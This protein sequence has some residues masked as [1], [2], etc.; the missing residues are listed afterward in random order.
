LLC[1]WN[2]MK[3]IHIYLVAFGCCVTVFCRDVIDFSYYFPEAFYIILLLDRII[4][5]IRL[6]SEQSLKI[7]IIVPECSTEW[8]EWHWI[9]C[10]FAY[11]YNIAF[12]KPLAAQ[13]Q[14]LFFQQCVGDEKATNL[15]ARA[16]NTSQGHSKRQSRFAKD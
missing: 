8:L 13:S 16:L 14:W 5:H 12:N 6:E 7:V 9:F 15:A 10:L 3:H 1:R 4:S 2:V 11:V